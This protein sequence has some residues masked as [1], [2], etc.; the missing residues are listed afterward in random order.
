LR[1]QDQLEGTE[2][3]ISVERRRYN[4]SVQEYN[5]Q[6]RSFPANL[7]ASM[8][9]FSRMPL[10]EADAGAQKAPKVSF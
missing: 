7:I 10:F 5:T 8:F 4:L 6:I 3:R 1:L 9:G 2:N